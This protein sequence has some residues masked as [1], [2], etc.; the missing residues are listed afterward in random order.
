MF[1]ILIKMETLK[2]LKQSS[3]TNQN[4]SNSIKNQSYILC[5]DK[6]KKLNIFY[7]KYKTNFNNIL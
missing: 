7:L 3:Y 2:L 6:L 5:T 4:R 1:Y